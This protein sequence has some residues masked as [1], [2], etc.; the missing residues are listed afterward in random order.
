MFQVLSS[1][2][3]LNLKSFSTKILKLENG[4]AWFVKIFHT[5]PQ[6][7]L[8]T[9]L[10]LNIYPIHFPTIARIVGRLLAQTRHLWNIRIVTIKSRTVIL[11]MIMMNYCEINY[12][13]HLEFYGASFPCPHQFS[14][15]QVLSSQIQANWI[16]LLRKTLVTEDGSA[17]F[18]KTSQIR[19]KIMFGIMSNQNIFQTRFPTI[20]HLYNVERC[21]THFKQYRSLKV[22]N[23][24]SDK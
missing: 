2:I 20:V 16:N 3:L 8:G 1:L 6:A 14:R 11:F 9:M 19:G 12:Y 7:A 4:S 5:R 18:V 24:S 10:S 13:L 22:A 23:T 21:F 15:F 17:Q